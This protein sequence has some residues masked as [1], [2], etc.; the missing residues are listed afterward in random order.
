MARCT[1]YHEV[2]V[3]LTGDQSLWR[4]AIEGKGGTIHHEGPSMVFYDTLTKAQQVE[5]DRNER[6]DKEI[7]NDSQT[8]SQTRDYLDF[9]SG[10]KLERRRDRAIAR[11][12]DEE[13]ARRQIRSALDED[14]TNHNSGHDLRC[15]FVSLVPDE[16]VEVF[17]E[18]EMRGSET[19]VLEDRRVV[20]ARNKQLRHTAQIARWK[21]RVWDLSDVDQNSIR[22][23]DY[24]SQAAK[25]EQLRL[26]FVQE[27]KDREEARSKERADRDEALSKERAAST[28]R[29][30][31][32]H[33][34]L[35]EKWL[36]RAR[37]NPLTMPTV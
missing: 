32:E 24:E 20:L 34:T 33:R 23:S 3:T 10:A 22:Y 37:D 18:A 4:S 17:T 7:I 9:T 5:A 31:E 30:V 29:F 25:A 14:K 6:H 15:G 27:T 13:T 2:D 12:A 28:A 8:E 16:D 1:E 35:G 11:R 36:K 26:A 21:P 19:T